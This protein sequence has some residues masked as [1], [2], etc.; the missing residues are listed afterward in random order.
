MPR[1]TESTRRQELDVGA[2]KGMQA[3][4]L[5]RALAILR[6]AKKTPA[7]K[8]AGKPAGAR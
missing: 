8:A 4:L 5:D 3:A 7:K 2:V 1:K 6:P